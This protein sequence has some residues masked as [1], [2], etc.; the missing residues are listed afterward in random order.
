[1]NLP[2][3]VSPKDVSS[4]TKPMICDIDPIVQSRVLDEVIKEQRDMANSF[5]IR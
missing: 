5:R 1:M 4:S 3:F 2:V